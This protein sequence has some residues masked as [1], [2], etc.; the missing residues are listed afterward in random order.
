M[1]QAVVETLLYKPE[2]HGFDAR[3]CHWNFLLTEPFRPHYG[4]GIESASNRNECQEYFLGVV[5]VRSR[6]KAMEFSLVKAAG[7][8]G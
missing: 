3:L 6:T 2:G 4:P 7:A 8:L 5:K 1:G